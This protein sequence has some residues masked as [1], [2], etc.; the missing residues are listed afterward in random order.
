MIQ[1]ANFPLTLVQGRAES[2]GPITWYTGAPVAPVSLVGCTAAFVIALDPSQPPL[3]SVST[4]PNAQGSIV[5]G[6]LSGTILVNLTN[7]ATAVLPAGL[8]GGITNIYQNQL[9]YQLDVTFPGFG[10]WPLAL[11]R[12]TVI[13]P[14]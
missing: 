13:A 3:I 5:L 7:A 12:V 11:G 6:G 10:A 14:A 1:F 4:T 9:R 2:I 8:T